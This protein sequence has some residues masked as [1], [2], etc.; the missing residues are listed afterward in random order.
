MPT[1]TIQIRA[2]EFSERG[3]DL[4]KVQATGQFQLLPMSAIGGQTNDLR[5]CPKR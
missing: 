3:I 5:T 4:A 1:Q 2:E